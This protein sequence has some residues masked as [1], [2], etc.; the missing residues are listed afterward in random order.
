MTDQRTPYDVLLTVLAEKFEVD[1]GRLEP[2]TTVENLDLDSIT[3]VE[4]VVVLSDELGAEID[5]NTLTGDL[6]LREVAGVLE[7]ATGARR[8]GR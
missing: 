8:G 4:L 7:D 5:E 3:L 6:T 1:P 2:D